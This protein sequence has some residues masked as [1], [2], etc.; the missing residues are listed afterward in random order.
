MF[1]ENTL[2]IITV[3]LH[4]CPGYGELVLVSAGLNIKLNY[5]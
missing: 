2:Q 4:F 1:G 3:S 5:V